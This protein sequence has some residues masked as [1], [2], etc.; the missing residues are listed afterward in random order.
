MEPYVKPWRVS[1]FGT[2][3]LPPDS[4]HGRTIVLHVVIKHL[5]I[6]EAFHLTAPTQE[7]QL[8]FSQGSKVQLHLGMV[9]QV[10]RKCLAFESH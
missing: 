1:L 10:G 6:L 5:A 9:P 4:Q 2:T 7:Q 8:V 3:G